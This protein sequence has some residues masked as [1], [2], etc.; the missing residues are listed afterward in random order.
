MTR[1]GRF[2][3]RKARDNSARGVWGYERFMAKKV[4]GMVVDYN[5][6]KVIS[7]MNKSG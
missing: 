5:Y 3:E 6:G 1:S 2:T 7:E 4:L